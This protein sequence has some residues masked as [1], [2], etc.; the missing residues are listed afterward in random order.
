[1]MNM[2]N[3]K[4]RI[5]NIDV[6]RGIAMI[7]IV[8]GH[9]GNSDINRIVFTF[10][11]PVFF[12]ITG[13]FL[14]ANTSYKSFLI[15]KV[16]TLIIPY[17]FSCFLVICSAIIINLVFDN[18]VGLK[19]MICRWIHASLYGAGDNY[20]QPFSIYAIGALWFLLATFW[21]TLVFRALIECKWYIRFSVVIIMAI[22]GYTTSRFL[23]WFPL[24][25]QAGCCALIYIYIGFIFRKINEMYTLSEASIE[26]KCV[27]SV[28]A[29]AI[30]ISF[31]RGF[32]SFWLVHFDLG[33]G[34]VDVFA[35][36]CGCY[37]VFLIGSFIDNKIRFL[38]KGL[39]FLGR[40]SIIFLSAHIVELNTFPWRRMYVFFEEDDISEFSYLIFRIVFK[41]LWII[42]FTIV[43][44]KIKIIRRIYGIVD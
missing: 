15:R 41:L 37:I 44:S 8:L 13:Y 29:L 27:I 17:Y 26:I 40:Y 3:K 28:S 31:I 23:F 12:L 4:N 36:L 39:A 22:L 11:L 5:E 24:S 6:V 20:T 32:Q 21:G 43:F 9:L 33:R 25:V 7:S 34:F 10:H 16:K 2:L 42:L 1:M 30:W 14:N 18:G 19:K 35:S 38:G